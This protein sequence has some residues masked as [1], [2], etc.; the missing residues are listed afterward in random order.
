MPPA[1][2]AIGQAHA[3]HHDATLDHQLGARRRLAQLVPQLVHH[4]VAAQGPVAVG[5]HRVLLG[6]P[7]QE[8]EGLELL[9]GRRPL[10]LPVEG[11]AVEL[12]GGRYAGRLLGQLL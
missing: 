8:P 5:Q 4:G 2:V 1:A 3:G 9:D 12:T 11:Q 10:A 7:G 6:G